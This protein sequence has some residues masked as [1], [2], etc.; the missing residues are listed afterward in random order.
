MPGSPRTNRRTSSRKRPFHWR[1]AFAGKRA[2]EL[3]RPRGIPRLCDQA[4][5]Y[6]AGR[7]KVDRILPVQRTVIVPR[8]SRGQVEPEPIDVHLL[9]PI[10]RAVHDQL[11]DAGVGAPQRVAGSGVVR[12]G[13][14]R[15]AG[16]QIVGAVVDPLKAVDRPVLVSFRRVVVDH[17]QNDLD[18]RGVQRLHHGAELVVLFVRPAAVAVVGGEKVQRHVTPTASL[19]GVAL[20]DGHEFYRSDP[21]FFQ[22]GNLF[23]DSAVG[24]APLRA[25]SGVRVV[26]ESPDVQ[27]VND[28]VRLVPRSSIVA[29]VELLGGGGEQ[30]QGRLASIGTGTRSRC[31]VEGR[32]EEDRFRVGIEKDL[33]RIKA[34]PGKSTLRLR[35]SHRIGVVACAAEEGLGDPAVPDSPRL[36]PEVIEVVR[37]HG[38]DQ[39]RFRVKQQR[40]AL[41]HPWSRERSSTPSPPQPR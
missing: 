11:S 36:V 4:N 39:V 8:Q 21:Q 29:P 32:G 41:P 16:H 22:I 5:V 12:V 35:A 13:I 15:L 14:S 24:A 3:V 10:T 26:R 2:S 30:A 34:V 25:H 37:E 7:S 1:Q 9:D 18:V 19:L 17:V 6:R 33:V 20:E 31:P 27:L 23:D 40:N 38:I 28:E